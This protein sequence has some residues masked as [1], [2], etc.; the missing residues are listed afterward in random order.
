M[1]GWEKESGSGFGLL[2]I[3]YRKESGAREALR[4]SI[5]IRIRADEMY[6]TWQ[7]ALTEVDSLS[8]LSLE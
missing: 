4:W 3:V 5:S 1:L 6:L 2:M 8:I 7:P